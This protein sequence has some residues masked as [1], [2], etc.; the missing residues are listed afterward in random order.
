MGN[1][2]IYESSRQVPQEAQKKITGGRLNGMTDINPMWRIKKLTELFGPAGVG[3]RFDPPAFEE[4]PGVNGEVMVHCFTCLYILDP[5]SG[6]WSAPIPGVGGAML[7]TTERSGQRTDDDAYKKAYTDAQSVA[8]KALGIGADVYWGT[9]KTKYSAPATPAD[10]APPP[11]RKPSQNPTPAPE[12]NEITCAD[13]GKP[14]RNVEYRGKVYTPQQTAASTNKKYGR[15]LCWDCASK[16][17]NDQ[18]KEG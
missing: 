6:A 8:C 5:E 18:P 12:A 3:W 9:D 17:K 11:R 13:C 10:S 15:T 16:L 4:K 7:I 2:R 1:L 14:L